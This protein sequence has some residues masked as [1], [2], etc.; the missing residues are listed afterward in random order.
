MPEGGL[1]WSGGLDSTLLVIAAKE[2]NRSFTICQFRAFMTKTQTRRSDALIAQLDIEVFSFPFSNRYLIGQDNEIAVVFE[3]A[4]G[5][6]VIP[7]LRD[8][9]DGDICVADIGGAAR[10]GSPFATIKHWIVGSRAD[11]EHYASPGKVIPAKTWEAGTTVFTAPLHDWT[12]NEVKGALREFGHDAT[13][14]SEIEDTNNIAI[15][16]LCLN[17]KGKVFCPKENTEI[18]AVIWD[19]NL[20]TRMFQEKFGLT[21]D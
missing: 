13:E 7:N 18:D 2:A 12:R 9:I 1:L 6:T 19:R 17:G 21:K 14:A 16:R 11:D 10:D 15:C 8:A 4:V 20:N 3:Y 5:D